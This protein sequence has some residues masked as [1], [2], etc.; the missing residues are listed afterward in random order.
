MLFDGSVMVDACAIGEP[1]FICA[2][3]LGD[4]E[5]RLRNAK[6]LRS[7]SNSEAQGSK[8]R[9]ACGAAALLPGGLCASC[10]E[11]LGAQQPAH[12][13]DMHA[14]IH[15]VPDIT[16]C[17]FQTCCFCGEDF[18]HEHGESIHGTDN[19][20][21]WCDHCGAR[22]HVNCAVFE[23]V[24]HVGSPGSETNAA[25]IAVAKKKMGEA[26]WFARAQSEEAQRI[27]RRIDQQADQAAAKMSTSPPSFL[28]DYNEFRSTLCRS[29]RGAL[30]GLGDDAFSAFVGAHANL[31]FA[32]DIPARPSAA[33][34]C[35]SW[36]ALG[37]A[38]ASSVRKTV[39]YNKWLLTLDIAKVS[40]VLPP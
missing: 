20:N 10:L 32:G 22:H 3:L 29:S 18:C 11:R 5:E 28:L 38:G 33:W 16:R 30:R 23:C 34:K 1:T 35:E 8:C 39:D 21:L 36:A 24:E 17:E 4:D 19:S 37:G 12:S 2:D 14:D 31:A 13:L 27:A 9:A 6:R 26:L 7:D 25:F 40:I 15:A